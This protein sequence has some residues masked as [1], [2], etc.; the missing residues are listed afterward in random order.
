ML[1]SLILPVRT[2]PKFVPFGS[3]RSTSSQAPKHLFLVYAPDCADQGTFEKRLE[4]R[5]KHLQEALPTLE[6]QADVS[7]SRSMTS[8]ALL[9][10]CHQVNH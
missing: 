1:R 7:M 6:P 8:L 2:L 10:N 4:V 3:S 5:E 9:A